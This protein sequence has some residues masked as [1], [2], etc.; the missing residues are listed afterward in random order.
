MSRAQRYQA[1]LAAAQLSDRDLQLEQARGQRE[2]ARTAQLVGLIPALARAGINIGSAVAEADATK[3]QQAL[4]NRK[5]DIAEA[6]AG[7]KQTAAEAA[8]AA[9]AARET[10]AA[11][12]AN[13]E[14]EYRKAK[15]AR[16]VALP[17][18]VVATRTLD[19][20]PGWRQFVG[21]ADQNPE[22]LVG[23]PTKAQFDAGV[24]D[25][26]LVTRAKEAGLTRSQL[27]AAAREKRRPEELAATN[28][29]DDIARRERFH[30]DSMA[31]A[32]A[33]RAAAAAERALQ[34]DIIAAQKTKEDRKLTA[35]DS[36]TVSALAEAEGTMREIDSEAKRINPNLLKSLWGKVWS[37]VGLPTGMTAYSALVARH[38]AAVL[39]AQS[40]AAATEAE[41]ARLDGFV[42]TDSDTIGVV[43]AKRA[44]FAA[45]LVEKRAALNA[46]RKAQG[47]PAIPFGTSTSAP[48]V[49]A[50]VTTFQED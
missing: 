27:E 30:S 11:E 15:D 41:V 21:E 1:L 29:A 19:A 44:A 8:A 47:L 34:R 6:A 28:R 49:P 22:R 9:T 45:Y 42:P 2:A 32:E 40:G 46:T 7:K 43:E 12:R 50:G 18:A 35:S 10:A 31:S 38:K 39:K 33:A 5:L 36:D 25:E 20:A 17:E 37:A 13:R 48:S 4:A 24:A 3:Q 16:E 23:P 14:F 26:T